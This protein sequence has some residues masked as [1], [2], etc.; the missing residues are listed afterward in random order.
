MVG[1]KDNGRLAPWGQDHLKSSGR[2]SGL[3][4]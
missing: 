3:A 2:N 1:R 4:A